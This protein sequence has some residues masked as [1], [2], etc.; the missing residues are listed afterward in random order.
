MNINMI[1][2]YVGI[3]HI[4][5]ILKNKN[6]SNDIDVKNRSESKLRRP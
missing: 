4:N 5:L 1:I 2:M 3:L 6:I